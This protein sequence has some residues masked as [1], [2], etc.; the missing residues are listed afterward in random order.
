MLG[1][2]DFIFGIS[3]NNEK[4]QIKFTFRSCPMIFD[5]VMALGL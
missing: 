5:R 1:D 2:I 4:L 3:V